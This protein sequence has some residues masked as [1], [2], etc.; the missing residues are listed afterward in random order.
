MSKKCP[1]ERCTRSS[2]SSSVHSDRVGKKRRIDAERKRVAS[3]LQRFADNRCALCQAVEVK[4]APD[5]GVDA[6]TD[7]RG[8]TGA[9]RFGALCARCEFALSPITA[10][11]AAVEFGGDVA[12]WIHRFKY[13]RP[14]LAGLDPA[15]RSVVNA[16]VREAA[17]RVIESQP[18]LVVPVP[19][20]PSRLRSRGFNPAALLARTV[21]RQHGLKMDPVALRRTRATQSQTG[22]DRGARRVNV[23][24]AFR[25]RRRWRAPDL[26]WLVDDVVTT[27]STLSECACALRRAGAKTV[28]GICIARTLGE[29]S[30][31]QRQAR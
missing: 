18:G 29:A 22:L 24:S 16:L 10:C 3:R 31:G 30:G 28:V 25:A 15:P 23:R 11:V 26:V 12:N 4:L 19:L 21:A 20:H 8:K 1:G 6:S 9:G 2:G 14:G 27:G 7:P 17:S 5:H 13:P